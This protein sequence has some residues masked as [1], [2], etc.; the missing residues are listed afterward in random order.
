M[1][2][3]VYKRAFQSSAFLICDRFRCPSLLE[4]LALVLADASEGG[5]VTFE[6]NLCGCQY[7]AFQNCPCL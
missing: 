1:A 5:I 3:S 6:D 2:V 4:V 7:Y